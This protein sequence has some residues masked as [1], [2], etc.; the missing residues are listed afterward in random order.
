M[1]FT[2]TTQPTLIMTL[3]RIL[4][5][6]LS[7][8]GFMLLLRIIF[9]WMRTSPLSNQEGP[10]PIQ[11]FIERITQP[12]LALFSGLRFLKTPRLDFTPLAAFLVLNF[13]QNIVAYFASTGTLSV[14]IL[15]AYTIRGLWS[16]L[17]SPVFLVF[18]IVLI[19]R[20]ILCYRHTPS[21]LAYRQALD[22]LTGWLVNGIQRR[23]YKER[24][25]SDKSLFVI[26]LILTIGLWAI[27][28]LVVNVLMQ[29]VLKLPF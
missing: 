12:Y 21:S 28:A 2:A 24:I 11:A 13:L 14:A 16:S 3:A 1:T 22:S 10:R 27:S 6:A 20:L 26:S 17:I 15:L 18:T 19:V 23:F 5:I 25:M 29:L 4:A 7:L 9:S 8:Y